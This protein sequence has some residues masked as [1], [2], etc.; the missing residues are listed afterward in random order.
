MTRTLVSIACHVYGT[1][2]VVYLAYLVRQTKVLATIGRALVAGG[3]LVHAAAIALWLLDQ[4]GRPVGIAQGFSVVAFLLLLI[5]FLVDW[6]YR[7]PVIGSFLTPVA[8]T[9]V[10][11]GLFMHSPEEPLPPGLRQ[12]LLPVHISI[13]LLGMAAFAVAAAVAVM[14]L[15]MERQMKG[16][17]FGVLFSRLPPLQTLDELNRRLVVWGFIALSITLVSG[18][19]FASGGT[20][21]FWRWGSREVATLIAWGLFATL[22]NFRFFAGWQG[23]RAALLTMAGFGILLISFFSYT[24]P[25]R[26]LGGFH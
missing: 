23:K 9:V 12:P 26:T 13:A 15:L 22:L 25:T 17:K 8:V 6:R 10:T 19:F 24:S 2:A 1:A 11:A 20:G 7:M 3:L 4:Q 21:L 14:Y 16:K 5:F 18:V